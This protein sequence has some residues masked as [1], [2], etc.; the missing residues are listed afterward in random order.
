MALI[1]WL[2][3]R[4]ETQI[5]EQQVETLTARCVNSVRERVESRSSV[6]T[7]SEARGY[8]RAQA[9][10]VLFQAVEKSAVAPVALH[11]RIIASAVERVTEALLERRVRRSE[12]RRLRRAA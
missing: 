1:A 10:H 8:I 2:R 11:D 6:L 5:V 12:S 3:R 4:R 9:T 7:A